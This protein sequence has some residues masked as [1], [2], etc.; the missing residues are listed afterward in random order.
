M[1]EYK[2][3]FTTL[4]LITHFFIELV[5]SMAL[6]YFIG[7]AIDNYLFEDKHIF[8]IIFIFLGLI[9]SLINLFRRVMKLVGG[10]KDADKKSKHD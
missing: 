1:N 5:V 9:S 2:T 8:I 7:K 3:A 6:G 10:K 4:Q